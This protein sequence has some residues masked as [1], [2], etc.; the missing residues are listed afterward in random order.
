ELSEKSSE[1]SFP[2]KQGFEEAV[3]GAAS[4]EISFG[5]QKQEK[6]TAGMKLESLFGKSFI[7]TSKIKTIAKLATARTAVLKKHHHVRCSQARSDVVQLLNL[8]RH[9]NA[10]LRV[11]HVIRE[12]NMF[13]V[14]VL[15]DG[16]CCILIERVTLTKKTKECPD[17]LKEAI[18]GL[19]FAASRCGEFP[20]LL[21][22]R[23]IFTERYGKE[24]A[25]HAIQP[26]NDC[27]VSVKMFSTRHTSLESKL[28][29]LKEIAS[30]NGVTLHLEDDSSISKE[31]KIQVN[32]DLQPEK[33]SKTTE[34]NMDHKHMTIQ[35]LP[36]KE[37]AIVDDPEPRDVTFDFPE[38]IGEDEKIFEG[39]VTPR[40]Y[41]DVA[42]AAGE[43]F[44]SATYAALAA[45]AAVELSRAD[46]DCTDPNLYIAH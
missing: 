11:E 37:C 10:F 36:V 9:D 29:V 22:L 4:E 24:F 1:Q 39:N 27:G 34:K 25:S 8:G 41:R 32:P 5:W 23:E 42:D 16:Y 45:R 12:Q 20:E 2:Y 46:S 21:K 30:E 40:R 17:E 15:V 26:S 14:L 33:G 44:R 19:I 31:E 13:D 35:Q 6:Q 28:K 7:S 18:S 43:A 38:I 3:L